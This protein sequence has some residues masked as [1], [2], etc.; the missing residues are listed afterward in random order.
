MTLALAWP[1]QVTPAGTYVVREQ[2]TRQAALDH[3][4]LVC[5]IEQGSLPEL[6]PELGLPARELRSA[7]ADPDSIREAIERQVPGVSIVVTHAPQSGEGWEHLQIT[8]TV[9]E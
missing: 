9:D 4:A 2:T 6:A 5:A 3:V 8:V 7:P 1:V